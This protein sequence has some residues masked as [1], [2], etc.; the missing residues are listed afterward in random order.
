MKQYSIREGIFE[1]N[2]SSAHTVT[3]RNVGSFCGRALRNR[4]S[5]D[6]D[7]YFS[8]GSFG[9]EFETYDEPQWKLAYILTMCVDS[10]YFAGTSAAQADTLDLFFDLI[11]KGNLKGA[12]K[13]TSYDNDEETRQRYMEW[14]KQISDIFEMIRQYFKN[15]DI[16]IN[17]I[18]WDHMCDY[19]YVDHQSYYK[20]LDDFLNEYNLNSLEQFVFDSSVILKTGNDNEDPPTDDW[21]NDEV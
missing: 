15:Q 12:C 21:Y 6:N 1:T 3:R 18:K 19:W 5:I 2:S 17:D 9:W 7:F 11:D 16:I 20:S 4:I 14:I 8:L 10:L 13:L